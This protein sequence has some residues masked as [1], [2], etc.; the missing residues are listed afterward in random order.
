MEKS[1]IK[2]GAIVVGGL[3]S[4]QCF[5]K[6]VPAHHRAATTKGGG[7]VSLFDGKT[8]KGWHTFNSKRL[9]RDW[10]VIDGSLVCLGPSA[11]AKGGDLVSDKEYANFELSWSWKIEKGSNS[12]VMYHVIEGPKYHATYETGPEYQILDDLGW[13][14]KLEDWQKAGCDYAMHLPNNQKKLMP[15]GDW[16]TSKIVFNH[17][18]VE[19]WLNGKKIL[20]FEA[21]TADWN[22]K[23]AAGK[24][25]DYPD[26]GKAKIGHIALQ[27]HG[28]KVYFRDIKIKA[29]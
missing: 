14:G 4:L 9:A 13:P 2:V 5:A 25:K 26:Y 19:H 3:I 1:L 29:L 22:K 27:E 23:K 24:W 8:L 28:H 20:E 10:T 21:W 7:W 17:G 6:P 18:H 12:G 11:D 15:V 16:N